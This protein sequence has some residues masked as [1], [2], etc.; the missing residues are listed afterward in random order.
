MLKP[1]RGRHKFGW[2][3]EVCRSKVTSSEQSTYF[4]FRWSFDHQSTFLS[5]KI[6]QEAMLWTLFREMY[7]ATVGIKPS[8]TIRALPTRMDPY[9][10]VY[11]EFSCVKSS[12]ERNS[13][14]AAPRIWS[15]PS[16]G[17]MSGGLKVTA[18]SQYICHWIIYPFHIQKILND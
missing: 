15:M 17:K 9:F 5:V 2:E 12:F 13:I 3:L 8:L 7:M 4:D 10:A 18:P 14:A 1:S 11:S 16:S 6:R